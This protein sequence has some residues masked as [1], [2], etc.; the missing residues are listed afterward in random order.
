MVNTTSGNS[1]GLGLMPPAAAA[2]EA[3]QLLEGGFK[4]VKLCLDYPTL[5]EDLQVTRAVC[6]NACPTMSRLNG[7]H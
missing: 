3:M 5:N 4:G 2:D 1:S 7:G 6:A